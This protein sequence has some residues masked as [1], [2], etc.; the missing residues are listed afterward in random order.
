MSL[1]NKP[2]LSSKKIKAN[3]RN[4]RKPK[5]QP[6]EHD[7]ENRLKTEAST[8]GR[9]PSGVG[10]SRG[11]SA[12]PEGLRRS[13][14]VVQ[15]DPLDLRSILRSLG[16][17][18]EDPFC[19]EP[20][21]AA[22]AA[23]DEDPTQFARLHEEL[24]DEWQPSTSTL[25]RLVLRLAYLM[26]RQER[27]QRAQ[28]G[29]MLCRM[30]KELGERTQRMLDGSRAPA[31]HLAGEAAKEGGLRQAA[32]SEAKFKR[33]L[34]WLQFLIDR[35]NNGNFSESWE[36]PLELIYGTKPSWRGDA[37]IEYARQ[38]AEY[39]ARAR[40]GQADAPPP[41]STA[42]ASNDLQPGT[43]RATS[44]SP[45]EAHGQDGHA[46]LGGTG[47]SPGEGE[48]TQEDE[49]E[50]GQESEDVSAQDDDDEEDEEEAPD[51]WQ[52]PMEPIRTETEKD[53]I[54]H[55]LRHDLAAEHRN[56]Q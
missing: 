30:E 4:G 16:G 56:R 1:V 21:R 2:Q 19:P 7:S 34:N 20:I 40:E 12:D 27:A 41:Q 17:V 25:R 24:I 29:L 55:N 28:D 8:G 35:L 36:V 6:G 26:W 5:G 54:L 47:V 11:N 9:P 37:I 32:P 44:V 46:T 45:V 38:L 39:F 18:L 22:L 53:E 13:T 52:P 48:A 49:E 3:R 14:A 43:T 15:A 50:N 42:E 31:E 10:S 51:P 23:M 33:L